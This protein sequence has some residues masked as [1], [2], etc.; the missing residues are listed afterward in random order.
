MVGIAFVLLGD[1]MFKLIGM[2]GAPSWYDRVVVKNAVPLM[3]GLYL[4]LPQILNG[5]AVSGAF[6]VVLN[7]TE[8]VFS[9]IAT[10]RMPQTD[11]LYH[12]LIK[13][14]LIA[15]GQA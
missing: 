12:A 9:K 8:I 7:G 11:D 2:Q 10:G 6:E 1:N 15:V 13:A 5:Y 14:G 4:I 3:I